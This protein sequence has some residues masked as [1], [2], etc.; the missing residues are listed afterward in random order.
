M[1][2]NDM[3]TSLVGYKLVQLD[4]SGF[5]VRGRNGNEKHFVFNEDYGDCCGFNTIKTALF[6]DPKDEKRVPAIT[7]VEQDRRSEGDGDNLLI[8][9]FGY[10]RRLAMVE[11]YSSFGS[12]WEYGATV[13]LTCR[14][15][16]EE[17]E[18]TSW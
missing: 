8:T 16:G 7:R 10:D 11:S 12:G 2:L 3:L 18:V 6:F 4:E 15:T 1:E 5:T 14:E 17:A 9:F 13:T